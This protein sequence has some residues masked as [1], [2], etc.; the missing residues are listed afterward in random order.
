VALWDTPLRMANGVAELPGELLER[1]RSLDAGLREV[2]A[3]LR[4]L[5]G[6][7]RHLRETVDDINSRFPSLEGSVK[8]IEEIELR[9]QAAVESLEIEVA[10]ATEHIP[11]DDK[12][13]LARARDAL[14]GD[15]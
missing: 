1:L 11:G 6:E 8:R 14:T 2:V 3:H 13:P 9:L 15:D 10:D 12:G 7:I 4:P 5:D